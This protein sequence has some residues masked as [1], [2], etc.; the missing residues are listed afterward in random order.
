M[1]FRC[2]PRSGPG[3]RSGG[4]RGVADGHAGNDGADPEHLGERGI[5]RPDGLADA[6]VGVLELGIEAAEIPEQLDDELQACP[7]HRCRRMEAPEERLDVR[8]VEFL[9]DSAWC[10]LGQGSVQAA[11]DAGPVV[12]DVGV[13]LG[14]EAQH[15]GGIGRDHRPL[16]WRPQRSDG[17][18]QRIVRVVLGRVSRGQHPHPRGQSGG[19]VDHVFSNRNELLSE[20]VAEPTGG[21]DGPHALLE[22]LGPVQQMLHLAPRRA[23]LH[24]RQLDFALADR[25]R[26]VGRLGG[27]TPMITSSFPPWSW[28]GPRRALLIRIVRAHTSF[29]PLRGEARRDA[30]R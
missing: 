19:H 26:G 29:E 13:A 21:L 8:S 15:L 7:L 24:P 4:R 14:Q 2:R 18:R 30:L 20:Q 11:H 12:A 6:A 23:H 3:S 27:S 9:G 28:W 10:Q 16:S 5:R 1:R 25:H 17:D 22:R